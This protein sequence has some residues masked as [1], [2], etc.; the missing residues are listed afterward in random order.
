M[1]IQQFAEAA[2]LPSAT[3]KLVWYLSALETV[4]AKED[5]GKRHKKSRAARQ[6][7]IK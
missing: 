1:G 2:R 6:E 5:E 3:I 4:L 7:A